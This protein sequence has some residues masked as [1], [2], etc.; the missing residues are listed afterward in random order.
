VKEHKK[1][2]ESIA[3]I[4]NKTLQGDAEEEFHHE[5]LHMAQSFEDY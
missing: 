1:K 3:H 2:G 4:V 5:T